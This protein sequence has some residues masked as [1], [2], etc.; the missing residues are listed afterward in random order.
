MNEVL[1]RGDTEEAPAFAQQEGVKWYIPHHGVYHPKKHKIRVVFDCSARFRG[2]SLNDHLLSGPDLTNNLVGVLRRFKKYPYAITCDVE[3]M[4]HRF[5]VR[6][7]DR[8]Y[9]Y[10]LWWPNGDVKKEPKEYGMK[11]HLFGA[12][13][14][15][16][17][18]S[19]GLKYMASQEEEVHPLAARFIMHDFY[20]DDRLTS[21]ES[22]QQ[23]EDLIQGTREICQKGRLHLHKFISNDCQVLESVPRSERAVDVILNLL[24]EQLPIESVLG[25]Q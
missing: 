21:V 25:V 12:T 23:A 11:V 5:I 14:S 9:L 1:S 20:V 24:F 15:P 16:G 19:Y 17:C 10:F 4:F 6:E 22:A 8:D 7:N 2:T 18:A 3:K 13:S